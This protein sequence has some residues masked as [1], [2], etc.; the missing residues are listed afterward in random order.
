MNVLVIGSGGR[1][2]SLAWKLAQSPRVKR[3]FVAPGNAGTACDAENVALS[4]T[5]FAKLIAFA[6]SNQVQLTVVGP[7]APLAAGLVDAMSA[8]GLRVFGPSRAA[9]ELEASKVFCKNLLRQADVPSAEYQVF[10]N[11][12]DAKR[13]ITDRYRD[14]TQVPVVVKADGLAAGKGVIVCATHDEAHRGDRSYRRAQGVW[15][16]R[17][18]V[19]H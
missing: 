13:Y 10:R 17:Q 5:D 18:P 2:H 1:E 9:A 8:A 4:A 3:V 7:E 6:K 12:D 11:A 14:M 15:R 16:S 19:D